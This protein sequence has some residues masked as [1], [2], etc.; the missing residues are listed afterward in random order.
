MSATIAGAA[1]TVPYSARRK[2]RAARRRHQLLKVATLLLSVVILVWTIM[3]IYNMMMVAL[4][5]EGDVFGEHIW[6]PK[7]SPRSFW[8][9]VSQGYWYLE[10][11]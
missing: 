10:Y 4:E 9:V 3:P 6:P 2:G 1:S 8:V 7:P 11:F 5:A